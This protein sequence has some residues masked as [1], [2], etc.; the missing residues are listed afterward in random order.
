MFDYQ[1]VRS[2]IERITNETLFSF[3]SNFVLYRSISTKNNIV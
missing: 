1:M 3:H 2:M